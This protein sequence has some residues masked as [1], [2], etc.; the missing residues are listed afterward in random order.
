[1]NLISKLVQKDL[2]LFFR[3]RFF[4]L[5]T[6]MG[7]IVYIVMYF[8]LPTEVDQSFG[9]AMYFEDAAATTVDETF[10]A[11]FDYT[12]FPTDAAL[13][14]AMEGEDE[15]I[16]GLSISAENATAL[17]NGIPTT[18]DVYYAPL[19]PAETQAAY[20]DMLAVMVNTANPTFAAQ[21]SAID[22][23][24]AVVL[25]RD[26]YGESI[27]L[28]DR[29]LPMLLLFI[30]AVEVM[31]LATLIIQ[32]VENGTARA[33]ITSP[34]RLSH[35]FASKAVMG[36]LLAFGQLLLLIVITG[37]ITTAPLPMVATL[38]LGSLMITGFGFLVA[39]VSKN[40]MSVMG[41]GTLL[42]M[43][44][45]LPAIA[46]LLPGMASGW[47][48]LIPS[49][50]F[51]DALH[52]ILNFGGGWVEIGRQLTILLVTGVVAMLV[53]AGALERRF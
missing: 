20:E 22:D 40:S 19:L 45:S 17:T 30:M 47:V 11:L 33:L 41:W 3:N 38:L 36:L 27:S 48:Q 28:R 42:I 18:V 10:G 15:Y 53:G 9:I 14:E 26:L 12:T 34:L 37:N 51:V 29:M 16:V 35:F 24:S 49:Y 52:S 1:M 13:R 44:F 31:G 8:L 21:F 2:K 6:L 7:L 39:A 5:V 43:V 4:A 50:F 25:G 23:D 46:L 32:E